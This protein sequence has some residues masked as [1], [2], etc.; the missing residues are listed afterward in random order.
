MAELEENFS[1]LKKAVETSREDEAVVDSAAPPQASPTSE[2]TTEQSSV[3]ATVDTPPVS[4]E[5]S[6]CE[7]K[8]TAMSVH[9]VETV[10]IF[11]LCALSDIATS[12]SAV[13]GVSNF[14]C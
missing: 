1:I 9:E 13:L 12:K 8:K 6:T 4:D 3:P 11:D 2:T 7:K 5:K 14:L 10:I